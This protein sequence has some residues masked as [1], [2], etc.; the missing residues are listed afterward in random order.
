[1]KQIG[2]I[3]QADTQTAVVQIKRATACGEN[4]G[5][6]SGCET[7]LQ[8]V[9]VSNPIGAEVGQVVCIEM[10][11][12]YILFA[13]FI[14]YIIPLIMLFLG[15][16]IGYFMWYKESLAII[17]GLLLMILSFL[18]LKRLDGRLKRSL[19]YQNKITKILSK[20]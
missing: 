13:A 16:G 9:E 20:S 3:I 7:T 18:I 12:R 14:V 4:C 10:D 8:R 1:M 11:D 17:S 6:C 2:I 5:N 15:Y 19:K